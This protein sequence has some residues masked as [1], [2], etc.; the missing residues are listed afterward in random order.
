V[1]TPQP[2]KKGGIVARDPNEATPNEAAQRRAAGEEGGSTPEEKLP[3][4]KP[5][6][7]WVAAIALGVALLSF[8]LVMIIVAFFGDRLQD[9]AA[10]TGALGSLFTLIGTVVG[11]YF[12]IKVS[13]DTAD[14]AQSALK[15]ANERVEK[16]ND[17]ARVA[18]GRLNPQ[19]P[20][21]GSL[22]AKEEGKV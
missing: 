8:V 11:A 15:V 19:D 13:N 10:L 14:R 20:D 7:F 12:G 5:Y 3:K 16:A 2:N 4:S 18:Y 22:L 1:C 6:A 21:V 17:K 9:V